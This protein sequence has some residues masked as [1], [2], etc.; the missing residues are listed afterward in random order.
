VLLAKLAKIFLV[1]VAVLAAVTSVGINW[2]ALAV[3]GGAVGVGI[4]FGLQ[5]VVSNLISGVI[6]LLDRSI[7]PG[8]VIEVGETYGWI[9][10]LA[11]RYTSVITR[12]G[13]EHLV[14]NEDMI[15]MPVINWTYSSTK[16]RRHIPVGVSYKADLRKAMDLMIAAALET[17][18]VLDDPDP[19]CLIKG[20]GDSAVNLEL[21]LWIADPQNGVANVASDVMLKIWDKF[22]EHGIEI[23]YPQRDLHLISAPAFDSAEARALLEK[24]KGL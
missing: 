7:K 9:N 19:K 2:A 11:A 16:V 4:G 1:T 17:P 24:L 21:R 13:R 14:P 18:R 22:H 20:F 15:T 6:L 10:K 5:K 23:P 3:F 8:D 12:D